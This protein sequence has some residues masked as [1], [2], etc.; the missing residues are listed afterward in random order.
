MKA[1]DYATSVPIVDGVSRVEASRQKGVALDDLFLSLSRRV[2]NYVYCHVRDPGTADDIVSSVFERVFRN[3]SKFDP[4][5]AGV[6][7]WV[8]AIAANAVRDHFRA[9]KR[10][11]LVSLDAV[12]E[13][14]SPDMSPEE[15]VMKKEMVAALLAGIGR[16]EQR[17]REIVTLKFAG[18][19]SNKAIARICRM[20][21]G[22]VAVIAHRAVRKLRLEI[23]DEEAHA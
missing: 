20:R 10:A 15:T 7:E 14:A 8:F 12:G 17:E 4:R 21:A 16:L 1:V 22:N 18:G 13:M 19:L 11:R 23:L 6:T 3:A 5:R 2:Y 9:R